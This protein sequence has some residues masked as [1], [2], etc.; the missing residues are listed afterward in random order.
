MGVRFW[1]REAHGTTRILT[2]FK[3][4]SENTLCTAKCYMQDGEDVAPSSPSGKGA[5]DLTR[6]HM[7][8]IW[9]EPPPERPSKFIKPVNAGRQQ[10]SSSAQQ[11][12]ESRHHNVMFHTHSVVLGTS[13][14]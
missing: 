7:D 8:I 2:S 1:K 3:Q 12:H 14:K 11:H 4:D 9:F 10:F 5:S 6:L 13:A